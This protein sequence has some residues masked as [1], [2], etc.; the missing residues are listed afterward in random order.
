ML[1]SPP[2]EGEQYSTVRS[3]GDGRSP[4]PGPGHLQRGRHDVVR[5]LPHDRT[6]PDT[7]PAGRHRDGGRLRRP[8]VP[9][10]AVAGGR[11]AR[12]AATGTHRRHR[13]RHRRWRPGPAGRARRARHRDR[14][15]RPGPQR[16]AGPDR[17]GLRRALRLRRPTAP[18][19]RRRLPRAAH[20]ADRHPG[21]RRTVPPR[22]GRAAG[23]PGP[24]DA[25][26]R[27]RGRP[28]GPA[29]RGPA[30]PGPA[31][32]GAPSGARRR[33]ISWPWPATPWPTCRPSPPTGP[34]PSSIPTRW[35]S[36]ATRPASGRWP[37]I[38]W[39]TPGSTR[40]RERA[41]TCGF[42]PTTAR[43]SSRSPTTGPGCPPAKRTS[44]SNASIGPTPPGP[45]PAT[46]GHRP[47]PV[48]RRRHRRRPRRQ[49]PRRRPAERPR[50]LLHGRP[51]HHSPTARRTPG[52]PGLMGTGSGRRI[53]GRGPA[54]RR[55]SPERR[56]RW[57]P[58]GSAVRSRRAGTPRDQ[59]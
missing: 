28:H 38:S 47:R 5:R 11:P 37:A 51:A 10:P 21:L 12:P 35:S 15:A 8:P 46:A 36:P 52:R 9:G 24:G 59:R 2:E 40:P 44:S 39:P 53:A 48:D 58:T 31:R 54:G 43:R 34:S 55:P 56:G 33:S 17:D 4:L 26:H 14:P 16:H 41:S 57:P 6:R 22:G 49:R 13:R 42:G 20:A 29:R 23:G 7:A 30:A 1:P 19:R 18:L 45:A 27:G 32:P 25:P 3:P 50:C